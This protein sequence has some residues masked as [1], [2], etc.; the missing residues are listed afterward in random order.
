MEKADRLAPPEAPPEERRAQKIALAFILAPL[1]A[2]LLWGIGAWFTRVP[3]PQEE[4]PP[5]AP[6]LAAPGFTFPA[7]AGGAVA[8][9]DHK[10]KLVLVNVWA[11][12]CPP[13]IEELPSLQ[14]LYAR[15]KGRGEPFEILAVSIDALGADAVQKFVDRFGLTFPILLDPRGRIKKLYRTTGVPETFVI[16]RDGRLVEK[17]IGSR[18]WDS[19][20]AVSYMEQILRAAPP[21]KAGS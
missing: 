5:V 15:M 1:L 8:L 16:G 12:W 9:S 4:L 2:T 18:T 14:R 21:A 17:V 11:T 3:A 7:L 10:G 6:G 13:C 20:E 19:P